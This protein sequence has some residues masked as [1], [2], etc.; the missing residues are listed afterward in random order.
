MTGRKRG[1]GL[2]FHATAGATTLFIVTV[3]AMIATVFADPAAP[4]N[5][6]LNRYGA[7]LL[8]VEVVLIVLSSLAAMAWDQRQTAREKNESRESVS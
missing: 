5:V 8:G 6:W 2:L 4:L 7:V 3:L 1:P